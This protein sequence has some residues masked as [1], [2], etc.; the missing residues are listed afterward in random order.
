MKNANRS[1]TS[2]FGE[3]FTSERE[4]TA[5]L[6][7]VDNETQRIDSRFLEPACGDG[8]FLH[9]ILN[10]KLAVVKNRYSRNDVE[11]KKYLFVAVASIYRGHDQVDRSAG[12]YAQK[13]RAGSF[14]IFLLMKFVV[15]E[16][17]NH[18]LCE[19]LYRVSATFLEGF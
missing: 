8:N 12:R 7:L 15:S 13:V 4:V 19:D 14:G 16:Q 5:M 6:N 1:R 9:E 17:E 11:F 18:E 3:V 10:R 2:E